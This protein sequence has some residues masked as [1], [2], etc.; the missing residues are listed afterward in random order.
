MISTV[1][2]ATHADYS[3]MTK[4]TAEYIRYL[5]FIGP[6]YPP[7]LQNHCLT[8]S[9]VHYNNHVISQRGL[10]SRAAAASLMFTSVI[11]NF[12]MARAAFVSSAS[13]ALNFFA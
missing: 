12:S 7:F 5:P 11:R 6:C 8:L 2:T 3:R 1:R 13:A 10:T 9:F 4:C